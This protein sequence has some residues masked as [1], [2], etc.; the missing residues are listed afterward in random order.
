MNKYRLTKQGLWDILEGWDEYLPGKVQVVACGGTALTLQDLKES[1]KDVDFLV[2]VDAECRALLATI[3]KL[4]YRKIT[5]SGWKRD[6][7]FIFDLYPGKTVFQTE[8]LESPLDAGNQIPVRAFK[9]LVVGALNDH[10]LIISKMFRGTD[11]DVDD[12]IRLIEARGAGFDLEKLTAR[13]KETALYELNPDKMLKNLD[14][15]L[16]ELKERS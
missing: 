7:G 6:D 13:Y 14:Y 16:A 3:Q 4:G 12:C 9:K 11:V 10:D 8:L 2:P 1:T 15:L 5:G